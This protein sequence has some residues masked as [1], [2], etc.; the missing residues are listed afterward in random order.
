[1]TQ[2]TQHLDIQIA[3]QSLKANHFTKLTRDG[4]LE[5]LEKYECWVPVIQYLEQHLSEKNSDLNDYFRIA[6][7]RLYYLDD[8]IGAGEIC[9]LVVRHKN[10]DYLT[11]HNKFLKRLLAEDD[12]VT[13]SFILQSVLPNFLSLSEKV[14]CLE[15]VCYLYEKKIYQEKLLSKFYTQLRVIDPSNYRALRY[16]RAIYTQSQIWDKALEVLH[17]M[18]KSARFEQ[19]T[20]R[21]AFEIA[22]IYLYQ[23][24][25]PKKALE[26]VN[27]YCSKTKLDTSILRFDAYQRLSD[28]KG[29]VGVLKEI[30]AANNSATER[31][32]IFFKIGV[33]YEKAQLF[34]A[35]IENFQAAI[36]LDNHFHEAYEAAIDIYLQL[37]NWH[38][39]TEL[40]QKLSLN[41][42]GL[43]YRI[44]LDEVLLRLEKARSHGN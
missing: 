42:A 9:A 38:K 8:Q 19:D 7:S 13:E 10:L 31:A 28:I 36:S 6:H 15:R 14:Q 33:L 17:V 25:D 37:K 29:S 44:Q 43:G 34:P 30:S 16:F 11:F 18:L 35:A 20:V 2:V 24:S 41:M 1:M 32:V 4:S 21:I 22:S 40:L 12:F 5:L 3:L 27:Q 23:L 39:I 26:F